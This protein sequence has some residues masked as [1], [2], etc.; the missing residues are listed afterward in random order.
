MEEMGDGAEKAEE[1]SEE[2]RRDSEY[3]SRESP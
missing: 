1:G 3:S 2:P